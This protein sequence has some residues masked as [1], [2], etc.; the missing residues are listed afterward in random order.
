MLPRL[1]IAFLPRSKHL[2]ISRLQ[3]PSAMILEP[4]KIKPVTVSIVSPS[5]SHEVMGPDAMILVFWILSFKP[6]FILLFH[7]H[8]EALLFFAF[9][10][11]VASSVYLKLF[12]FLPAILIPAHASPSLAF[13]MV[14]S[15]YKLNK[16]GD[17]IESWCTPFPIW[18]QSVVPFPFL[19]VASWPAHR[20]L[21][22]QVSFSDIPIFF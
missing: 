12:K 1:V 2:L 19:T 20:F 17:N 16:Q 8:Q 7:L 9:S 21:N 15:A 11:S 10:I 5:I 18:N 4:K 3:L 6:V 22:R 14:Y 13:C